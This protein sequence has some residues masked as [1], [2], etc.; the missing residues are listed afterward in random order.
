MIFLLASQK[1]PYSFYV[2]VYGQINNVT[3]I[4]QRLLTHYIGTVEKNHTESCTSSEK[5][6]LQ[7]THNISSQ[8]FILPFE[9]IFNGFEGSQYL[10][11]KMSFHWFLACKGIFKT[12]C[13]FIH[14]QIIEKGFLKLWE[15]CILIIIFFSYWLLYYDCWI[16]IIMTIFYINLTLIAQIW[17]NKCKIYKYCWLLILSGYL[18][19]WYNHFPSNCENIKSQISNF[20]HSFM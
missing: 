8:L 11:S 20:Y 16:L 14:K 3:R 13:M 1:S 7:V 6:S 19:M 10:A 4:I 15:N 2:S 5:A 18:I 9:I 17:K 12:L